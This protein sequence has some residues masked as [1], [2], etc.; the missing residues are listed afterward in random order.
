MNEWRIHRAVLID[1]VEHS[2]WLP[3]GAAEPERTQA[4][5]VNVWIA[6]ERDAYYL[7]TADGEH[8]FDSWHR[9]L[10]DAMAQAQFAYGVAPEEWRPTAAPPN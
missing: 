3:P 10:E 2:G 1:G 6:Y 8:G 9:T 5:Y 7:F 4:R